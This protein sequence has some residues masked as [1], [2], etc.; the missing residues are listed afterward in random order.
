MASEVFEERL[1]HISACNHVEDKQLLALLRVLEACG[2]GVKETIGFRYKH[3]S[4]RLTTVKWAQRYAATDRVQS[5]VMCAQACVAEVSS[6]KAL[7]AQGIRHGVLK[8]VYGRAGRLEPDYLMGNV[9]KKAIADAASAKIRA[10]SNDEGSNNITS[11]KPMA[12]APLAHAALSALSAPAGVPA[13]LGPLGIPVAST[14]VAPAAA[15]ADAAPA[16]AP[17]AAPVATAV[18][19]QRAPAQEAVAR[20]PALAPTAMDVEV[21]TAPAL[22]PTAMVVEAAMPRASAMLP[23]KRSA[24]VAAGALARVPSPARACSTGSLDAAEERRSRLKRIRL[25][26]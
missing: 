25:A 15:A 10:I 18:S 13:A 12:T 24:A 19:Q 22:A 26:A 16:A 23:S 17:A 7:E 6:N 14:S 11:S 1:V 21:A 9:E 5:G 8:T 4:L 2:H 20:A 3:G